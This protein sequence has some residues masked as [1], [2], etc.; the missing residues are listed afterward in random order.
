MSAVRTVDRNMAT[1]L[2]SHVV[3][4]YPLGVGFEKIFDLKFENFSVFRI[5]FHS[6]IDSNSNRIFFDPYMSSFEIPFELFESN[7]YYVLLSFLPNLW[8]HERCVIITHVTQLMIFIP[9]LS[10]SFF[11]QAHK[12]YRYNVAMVDLRH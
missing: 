10:S 11:L 12:N 6:K 2:Y 8:C 7:I 3:Y 9:S 5:F 4:V 1:V